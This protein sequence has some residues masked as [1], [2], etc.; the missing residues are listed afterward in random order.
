MTRSGQERTGDPKILLIGG[1]EDTSSSGVTRIGADFGSVMMGPRPKDYNHFDIIVLWPDQTTFLLPETHA[2]WEEFRANHGN[3]SCLPSINP[4][5]WHFRQQPERRQLKISDFKDVVRRSCVAPECFSEG[6]Q[7]ESA[8]LNPLDCFANPLC[9]NCEN[10]AD[11]LLL[12][13]ILWWK[14]AVRLRRAVL[15]MPD[16]TILLFFVPDI[17][18]DV[19]WLSWWLCAYIAKTPGHRA[20]WCQPSHQKKLTPGSLEALAK[21][22]AKQTCERSRLLCLQAEDPEGY[23][24][25]RL[26]DGQYELGSL[27]LPPEGFTIPGD[28]GDPDCHPGWGIPAKIAVWPPVENP[29]AILLHCESGGAVVLPAAPPADRRLSLLKR[30][31]RERTDPNATSDDQ[32]WSKNIF[33]LDKNEGVWVCKIAEEDSVKLPDSL[34]GCG[35]YHRLLD[36]ANWASGIPYE[37]MHYKADLS[38]INKDGI[39]RLDQKSRCH[40]LRRVRELNAEISEIEASRGPPKAKMDDQGILDPADPNIMDPELANLIK[41]RDKI[42]AELAKRKKKTTQE[43]AARAS[44]R[45]ALNRVRDML[46]KRGAH[47]LARHLKDSIKEEVPSFIYTGQLKWEIG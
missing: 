14:C 41:D 4:Q 39:E 3:N 37:E 15:S 18:F 25:P 2:A 31:Y 20:P 34:K 19:P 36:Q 24:P 9:N 29:L 45:N 33:R 17:G 28:S 6:Y 21:V 44:V 27:L 38:N 5:Y 40:L 30:W 1:P 8:K 47:K 26:M 22:F 13:R 16:G 43:N 12:E 7:R 32:R 46:C 35:Y 42:L 23:D 10:D 11:A